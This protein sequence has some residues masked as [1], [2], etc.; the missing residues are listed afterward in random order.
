MKIDEMARRPCPNL[1][2]VA[3]ASILLASAARA[4]ESLPDLTL[5]DVDHNTFRLHD[6]RGRVVL[7]DLVASWCIVCRQALP[8]YAEL[9]RKYG[10]AVAV[11]AV[12]VERDADDARTWAHTLPPEIR[13]AYDADGKAAAALG[14]RAMP[15]LLIV[16]RDG[17]IRRRHESFTP[18]DRPAIESLVR[19]LVGASE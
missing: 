2:A 12:S 5:T 14:M 3:L 13:M 16:D 17:R 18:D 7:V 15:T 4:S 6:L 11:V 19:E 10:D 1:V 8:F 9:Q